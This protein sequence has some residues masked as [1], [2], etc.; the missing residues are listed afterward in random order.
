MARVVVG[1]PL[2]FVMVALM[3]LGFVL[4]HFGIVVLIW[5]LGIALLGRHTRAGT[6][7]EQQHL[8]ILSPYSRMALAVRGWGLEVVARPGALIVLWAPG[9]VS[10]RRG[11]SGNPRSSDL[12]AS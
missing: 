5:S 11:G 2:L 12:S 1:I 4:A 9:A 6:V 10:P 3:L 7:S 8:K